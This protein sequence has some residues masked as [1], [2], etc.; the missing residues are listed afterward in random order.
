M[1]MCVTFYYPTTN[2][3]SKAWTWPSLTTN[4]LYSEQS[5]GYILFSLARLRLLIKLLI[6]LIVLKNSKICSYQNVSIDYKTCLA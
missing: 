6:F 2:N 1:F 3:T 4:I 5:D